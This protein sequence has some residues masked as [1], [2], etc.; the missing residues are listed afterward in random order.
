VYFE[1]NMLAGLIQIT[2]DFGFKCCI[3]EEKL[4]KTLQEGL[5]PRRNKIHQKFLPGTPGAGQPG[6]S[7]SAL[8]FS[9]GVPIKKI[10]TSQGPTRGLW[11]CIHG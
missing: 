9:L 8:I 6:P 3:R 4:K 2:N 5:Q 11:N 7:F 1:A 10:S